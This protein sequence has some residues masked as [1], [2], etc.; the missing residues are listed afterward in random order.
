MSAMPALGSK[1]ARMESAVSWRYLDISTPHDMR[2]PGSMAAWNTILASPLP[3]SRNVESRPKPQHSFQTANIRAVPG[4]L[5]SPYSGSSAPP[6]PGI[7]WHTFH[8]WRSLSW[9]GPASTMGKPP[10][11]SGTADWRAAH[12]SSTV[13]AN[14]REREK[15]VA[16]HGTRHGWA[17]IAQARCGLLD[18]LV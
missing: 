16:T 2:T 8:I 15:H 9:S 3:T 4:R 11:Y 7:D 1:L 10:A 5:I 18:P 12:A 14:A 13:C 6:S 17:Y